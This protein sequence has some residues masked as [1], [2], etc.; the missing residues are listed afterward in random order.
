MATQECPCGNLTHPRKSCRCTPQEVRRYLGKISGPLLDRI[1]MHVEVPVVS[2][3]DL[4]GDGGGESSA[5]IGRRVAAARKV[6]TRRLR[7]ARLHT[8]AQMPAAL[9]RRSCRLEPGAQEILRSAVEQFG[10]SARGHDRLLKVARTIADLAG[11]DQLSAAHVAEALQYRV[12][13]RSDS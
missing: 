4:A 10:L 1:D 13:D 11:A 7:S 3:A 12:L 5:V 9:V 2:W 8:N 6:Q